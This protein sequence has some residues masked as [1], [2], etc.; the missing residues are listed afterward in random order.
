MAKGRLARR[1]LSRLAPRCN[2][3]RRNQYWD[4][5]GMLARRCE[6]LACAGRRCRCCWP[7]RRRRRA[8][9]SAA[10]RAGPAAAPAEPTI[11]F[12]A[13]QVIYDSDSRLVV[14]AGPGAD[15]ARRQLPRRRPGRAGTA[16]PARSVAEG[17]VVVVIPEGDKLVGDRVVLDR[18]ACATARSRICWSC[19]KA[20]AAS[21]RRAARA[22]AASTQLDNAIY[23]PCPV[24]TPD[25]LPAATRAGRS[26]R[27][28]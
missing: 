2:R 19:S 21:P 22:P 27:R 3:P 14:A 15:G 23:S 13:D 18:H 25:R 28:A 1:G 10:R 8:A 5:A 26:P 24:T 11:D 6:R 4:R 17:N 7:C 16:T 9:G 12:S 20:A